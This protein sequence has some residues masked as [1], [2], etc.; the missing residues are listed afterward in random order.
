MPESATLYVTYHLLLMQTAAAAFSMQANG[1][2]LYAD[3]ARSH[4]WS[5]Q[6][7]PVEALVSSVACAFTSDAGVAAPLRAIRKLHTVHSC[8]NPV[9][10]TLIKELYAENRSL[11]PVS[12]TCGFEIKD[13]K[14]KLVQS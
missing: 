7:N 1:L 5:V 10:T 6:A 3:A 13:C 9:L 2:F 14:H 11:N 8:L 4:Q 12:T